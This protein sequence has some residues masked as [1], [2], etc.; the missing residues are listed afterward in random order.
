MGT[1]ANVTF[2]PGT[3][4][5]GFCHQ[6][7]QL[8]Y[9]AF[10]DLLTG[11]VDGAYSTFNYGPTEPAAEDQDKPWLKTAADGSPVGWK[12]YYGGAWVNAQYHAMSPGVIVDYY[13]LEAQ[14]PFLDDPDG[15]GTNPFWKLC[16]G[17]G[18]TPDLRGRTTIGTGAGAGLTSRALADTGGEETHVLA[19]T[20]ANT[21]DHT[22]RIGVE[23]DG[24]TVAA[25]NGLL[26]AGSGVSVH[27]DIAVPT[28]HHG[29]TKGVYGLVAAAN[30]AHEN[31]PPFMALHKIMRTTRLY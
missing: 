14:I 7:W 18:G 31:M 22:H 11:Y 3:L 29:E 21:I 26:S 20:E 10:I 16:D 9:N 19:S 4:P 1:N 12:I 8:T 17:T 27:Y 5:A 6:S 30:D 13:G 23:A 24:Y 15:D 25:A 2:V 28:T